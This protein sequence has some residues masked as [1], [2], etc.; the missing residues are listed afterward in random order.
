MKNKDEKFIELYEDI[1]KQRLEE[2]YQKCRAAK[3]N[4]KL[5]ITVLEGS[6]IWRQLAVLNEYQMDVEVC[7]R[8]FSRLY[9]DWTNK[10]T[11]HGTLPL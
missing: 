6:T 5:V 11:V 2:M 10:F 4:C 3:L 9:S 8:T 1:E 7:T